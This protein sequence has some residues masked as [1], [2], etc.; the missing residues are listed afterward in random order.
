MTDWRK[1]SWQIGASV[2]RAGYGGIAR[3]ARMS[4][5]ALIEAGVECDV[6]AFV[7]AAPTEMG[8]RRS[9]ALNGSKLQFTAAM[10]GA[11]LSHQRFLYDAVGPAR[12][13]P[14]LSGLRRPYGIWIH[15]VEVWDN[16][17]SARARALRGADFV[18]VNSAFTKWRFAE[19][20]W[21][22]ENAYICELATEEDELPAWLPRT[23]AV[24]TVLLIGRSDKENFRKG[25]REVI[26]AWPQVTAQIPEAQLLLAGGGDGI[27]LL[28]ET[29]SASPGRDS[30]KVLG[31][32][33]E[34]QMPALWARADVFCQ[35]S[36]KE[37]FGLVYIEAMRRG[38]P[39][40]ASIHDAGQEVN[41]EGETGFNVDLT[42]PEMLAAR[43]VTLLSDS[44]RARTMGRAG[45]ARWAAQYRYSA[46]RDRLWNILD[47][48]ESRTCP[49]VLQ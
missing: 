8:G 6:A 2:M 10:Y 49:T 35:P 24:P 43:I 9:R 41:I 22:L 16:L 34:E 23:E 20:H 11:A 30:I 44:G 7:D 42:D 40:I 17:S 32:V 4:T 31:F 45:Q 39:V 3:V 48:L 38:L 13:H 46:F 19:L 29:V 47:H 36:W 37:G 12:A 28:R 1:Q 21:P 18:L 25:H 33:P 15:G 26:G 14:R 27:E 5:R